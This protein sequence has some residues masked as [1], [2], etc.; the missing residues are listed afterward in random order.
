MKRIVFR[1]IVAF[2][3]FA[4]GVGLVALALWFEHQ[5]PVITQLEE[6]PCLRPPLYEKTFEPCQGVDFS[7]LPELPDVPFCEL[8]GNADLYDGKIV[9]V[10]AHSYFGRH[11]GILF[12]RDC[13]GFQNQ[14][15]VWINETMSEKIYSDFVE[16][17][18]DW[19]ANE[20][21]LIAVGRFNKVTPTYES[22]TIADT[23]PLK[24]E[25]MSVEKASR[26]R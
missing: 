7:A 4:F 24:F 14:T 1:S 23:A 19:W 16:N 10:N 26:V 12:D 9:R 20:I 6:P 3:A 13:S 11:G 18:L 21:D 22:D 25:I 2:A 5:Q 15:A 17:R 8:I